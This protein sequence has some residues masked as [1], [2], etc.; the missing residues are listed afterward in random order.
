MTSWIAGRPVRCRECNHRYFSAREF[1]V[2][3][4]H[5]IPPAG[6]G[7]FATLDRLAQPDHQ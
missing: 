2:L 3:R 6:S 7:V 5:R 1:G 4:W